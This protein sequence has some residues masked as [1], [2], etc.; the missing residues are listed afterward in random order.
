MVRNLQLIYSNRINHEL[1]SEPTFPALQL[2]LLRHTLNA[3]PFLGS[4]TDLTNCLSVKIF[5]PGSADTVLIDNNNTSC[6]EI[7][8]PS[9]VSYI[10]GSI[11][12]NK[13]CTGIN[14]NQVILHSVQD[15]ERIRVCLTFN[16]PM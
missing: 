15:L 9:N 10:L 3:L 7:A 13:T 8:V 6:L 1:Y 12:V 2:Y 5:H 14:T 11:K 16:R 4:F